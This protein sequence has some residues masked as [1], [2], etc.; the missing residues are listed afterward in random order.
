MD[1]NGARRKNATRETTSTLKA[2]LYEHRKNPYPTKGKSPYYIIIFSYS[3]LKLSSLINS[4]QDHCILRCVSVFTNPFKS[5]FVSNRGENHVGDHHKDDI[6]SS[7]YV[8]CQCQKEAQKG[9]Q[10]DLVTKV[11][12]TMVLRWLL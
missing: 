7:F 2:W 8:V 5:S 11:S 10:D 9:K 1:L 6:D 12:F 3:K 4:R